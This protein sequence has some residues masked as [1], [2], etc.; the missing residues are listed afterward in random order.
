M[1]K[2]GHIPWN[3]GKIGLQGHSEETKRKI[4]E[5]NIGKHSKVFTEE[6]KKK[7]SLAR[8]GMRLSEEHKKNIS[9]AISGIKHPLY[10]R[11]LSEEHKKKISVAKKGRKLTKEHKKKIGEKSEISWLNKEIRE[12]RIQ[13]SLKA[14]FEIRPTSLEKEMIGIIEKYQLPYE[15]TGDGRFLIGYKNPDFVN[16]NGEKICIEIG[17][18]FHHDSNYERERIVH[19]A[20]YGWKCIV[21][22]M[23]S[24]DENKVLERLK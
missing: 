21:F 24:L 17:N 11:H 19:F 2:K 22:I 13:N 20:K 18:T 14:L 15:Y 16:I 9:I 6:H 7:L 4:Q 12:K 10:G 1:Y 8:K 3:K 23:D 5:K